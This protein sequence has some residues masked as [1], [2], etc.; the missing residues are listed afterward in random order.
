[1]K[2]D[3]M[4]ILWNVMVWNF[5]SYFCLYRILCPIKSGGVILHSVGRCEGMNFF[6]STSIFDVY[7]VK[8]NERARLIMQ[9]VQCSR[10][11]YGMS[12][13]QRLSLKVF[14]FMFRQTAWWCNFLG[15]MKGWTTSCFRSWALSLAGGNM[16]TGFDHNKLWS[17]FFVRIILTDSGMEHVS[18]VSSASSAS[19]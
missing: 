15:D 7:F 3:C 10:G 9:T 14:L 18:D 5:C 12:F 8:L 13:V 6:F 1:M 11:C 4:M 16:G 19:T 2:S 17:G